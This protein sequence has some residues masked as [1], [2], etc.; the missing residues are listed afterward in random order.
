MDRYFYSIGL[1]GNK[2]VVHMSGNVYFNDGDETETCYRVAE[3]TGLYFGINEAQ[4]MLDAD[5]FYEYLNER[6]NY[7]GDISKKEADEICKNYFN[8]QSGIRLHIK[9]VT[10][11]TPCGDY[12]FE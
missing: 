5:T 12:W 1:D 6:V 2:K 7:L 11:D 8:G 10:T 3:W 9:D 4:F